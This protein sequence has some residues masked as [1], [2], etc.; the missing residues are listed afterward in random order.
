MIIWVGELFRLLWIGILWF[1]G[2]GV[3]PTFV[4]NFRFSARY[5]WWLIVF[6]TCERGYLS[7]KIGEQM[8]CSAQVLL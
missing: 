7:L 8:S 6:I 4:C 3:V 5:F 2:R 1:L